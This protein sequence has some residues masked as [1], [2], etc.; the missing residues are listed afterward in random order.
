MRSP[1]KRWNSRVVI[2]MFE[3]FKVQEVFTIWNEFC[4]SSLDTFYQG[5]IFVVT[6]GC[7]VEVRAH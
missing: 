6:G 4:G 2:N 3:A 7:I 5:Y 1:L